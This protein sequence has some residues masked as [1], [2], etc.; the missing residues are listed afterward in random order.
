MKAAL[1]V[2]VGYVLGRRRKKR[3]ARVLA[4]AAMAGGPGGL[5]GAASR[6]DMTMPG[7]AQITPRPGERAGT[8]RGDLPGAGRLPLPRRSAAGSNR[9]RDPPHERAGLVRDPGAA[10]T[11]PGERSRPVPVRQP[12]ARGGATA[13]RQAVNTARGRGT[14]STSAK[15]VT[16][17]PG[18]SQ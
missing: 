4:A 10:V 15:T 14:D 8:V 5:G 3:M 2:D 7:P 6:R 13:R 18:R 1:A 12:G 16:R 11:G 17:L 9:W